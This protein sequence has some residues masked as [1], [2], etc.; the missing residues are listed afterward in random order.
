MKKFTKWVFS[1]PSIRLKTVVVIEIVL[2][3]LVSLG[4][5]FFYSRQMLVQEAKMDAEQKLWG[6]QKRIDNILLEVEQSAGNIYY[7]LIEH[8]DQ[9]ELLEQYCRRLVQCNSHIEG[10]AIAFKPNYYPGQEYFM[11]YVRRD[12]LEGIVTVESFGHRLYTEQ[13][14]FLS[15]MKSCKPTW[16]NPI[17]QEEV[18]EKPV[19]AFCIPIF[20]PEN[21]DECIAVMAATL[22]LEHLSQVIRT[23]RSTDNSYTILLD[24]EGKF[25]IHPD[26]KT[27]YNH[28][29]F[30]LAE[31]QQSPSLAEIGKTIFSGE[32]GNQSFRLQGETWYVFYKPF[33]RTNIPGRS[34][35]ELNWTIS[36]IYPKS[37]IFNEYNHHI[38]HILLITAVGLLIFY[39]FTRFSIR[40]QLKP[41]RRLTESAH[42]IT[43]GNYTIMIPETNRQDEV[44][45]F[46]QNFKLMQEALATD[47]EQHQQL[48]VTLNKR[49]EELRKTHQ[50]IQDDDKVM[51]IFLHNVTNRMVPPAESILASSTQLCDNYQ[52]ITP[53]QAR[54]EVSN[55]RYQSEVILEL[56]KKKF[57]AKHTDETGKEE[58][59]E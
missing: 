21:G 11:K 5:L 52:E 8:L 39:I 36:T 49:R 50:Q 32:S 3:L 51:N 56:L 19:V 37:D 14:W 25:I 26:M 55:I 27:L 54:D 42:S 44:G 22:K 30:S 59:H 57:V 41:L 23:A 10:C 34:V 13:K 12:D 45:M 6:N 1:P 33:E 40:K 38:M 4:T 53:E 58:S 31:E 15:P 28:T 2:L 7:D 20:N 9:P 48:T 29:I 35:E 43:E 18:F 47:I 17:G 24:C 46:Q 16:L